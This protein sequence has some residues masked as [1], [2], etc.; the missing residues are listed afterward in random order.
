MTPGGVLPA[1]L[2]TCRAGSQQGPL[3][4]SQGDR[5]GGAGAGS[6]PW[7]LAVSP[8]CT[9]DPQWYQSGGTGTK[10]EVERA[11]PSEGV[12]AAPIPE[13]HSFPP[14]GLAKVVLRGFSPCPGESEEESGCSLFT[15]H[16]NIH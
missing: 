9:S 3:P 7:V 13:P 16:L 8:G 5:T 1:P 6:V 2:S 12:C 15:S 14:V 11:E 4:C 10:R